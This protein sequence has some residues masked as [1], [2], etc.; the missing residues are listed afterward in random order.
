LL[1]EVNYRGICSDVLER[2]TQFGKRTRSY[3]GDKISPSRNVN[4]PYFVYAGLGKEKEIRELVTFMI[5]RMLL[6]ERELDWLN[7]AVRGNW[8][9]LRIG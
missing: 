2:S 6:S 3:E 4:S 8:I 9:E 7:P 1:V 5:G